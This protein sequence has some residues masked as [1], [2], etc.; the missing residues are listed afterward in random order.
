M[1]RI[2]HPLMLQPDQVRHLESLLR[3]ST[4][5]LR[6]A[7]RCRALLLAADGLSNTEI[8]LQARLLNRIFLA[9]PDWTGILPAMS[10]NNRRRWIVP[11]KD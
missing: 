9:L 6:V 11:W 5:E 3:R 1:A 7:R 10:M 8:F 4:L 2:A